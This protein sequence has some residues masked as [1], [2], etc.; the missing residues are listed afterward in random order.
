MALFRLMYRSSPPPGL[1][2]SALTDLVHDIRLQCLARNSAAELTGILAY[3]TMAF[4]QSL[5]GE[6][7]AVSKLYQRIQ[8]DRRHSDVIT[9]SARAVMGRA[10]PDWAMAFASVSPSDQLQDMTPK[11]VLRFLI[12]AQQFC[13]GVRTLPGRGLPPEARM[14]TDLGIQEI[15]RR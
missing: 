4:V 15:E 1:S 5:E 12:N 7:S 8:A 14:R 13:Q 6:E 10:F 3:S 2:E 9:I 11:D